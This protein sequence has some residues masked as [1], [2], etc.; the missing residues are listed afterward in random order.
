MVI[1]GASPVPWSLHVKGGAKIQGHWPQKL[2]SAII[3]MPGTSAA[4]ADRFSEF[5]TLTAGSKFTTKSSVM[6]PPPLK[7]VSLITL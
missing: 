5:S 1:G 6:I 2:K 7:L 3:L 4:D